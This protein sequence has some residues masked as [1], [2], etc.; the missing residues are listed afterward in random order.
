[1]VPPT[2]PI[3]IYREW[4]SLPTRKVSVWVLA[5]LG[6]KSGGVLFF[7]LGQWARLDS[8]AGGARGS[9][10][11]EE[12]KSLFGA[13]LSNQHAGRIKLSEHRPITKFKLTMIFLIPLLKLY[14]NLRIPP[15][16]SVWS[17]SS[18]L[19]YYTL[20]KSEI[21]WDFLEEKVLNPGICRVFKSIQSQVNAQE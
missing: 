20:K 9:I 10:R 19:G 3:K 4:D 16:L 1:M 13:P 18:K 6:F 15:F 12:H 8:G 14:L 5:H 11:R 21:C 7:G 2:P 17:L